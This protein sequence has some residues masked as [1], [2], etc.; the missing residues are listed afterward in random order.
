MLVLTR[1]KNESIIIGENIEVKV[2]EIRGDKVKLGFNA[3]EEVP[4]HR[5]EVYEGIKRQQKEEA[6]DLRQEDNDSKKTASS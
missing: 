5:R 1:K 3:P 6:K 4:I 2:V